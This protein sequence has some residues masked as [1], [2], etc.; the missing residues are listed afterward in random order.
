MTRKI[1]LALALLSLLLAGSYSTPPKL[2]RLTVVNRSGLPVEIGLTGTLVNKYDQ[3]NTYYLRLPKNVPNP[4][5]PI[6]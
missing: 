5:C 1:L 4:V 3:K 6:G 2:I